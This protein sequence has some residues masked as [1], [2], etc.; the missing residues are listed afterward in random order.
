MKTYTMILAAFVASTAMAA[1]EDIAIQDWDTNGDGLLSRTEA[2]AIQYDVFYTFD[3]DED[4]DLKGREREGFEAHLAF[5]QSQ[6]P[7]LGLL[8]A[9]DANGDGL[10]SAGEFKAWTARMFEMMDHSGDGLLSPG[11]MLAQKP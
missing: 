6:K 9:P 7:A 10:I 5:R 2:A 3:L 1:P 4:G 8:K 11:E